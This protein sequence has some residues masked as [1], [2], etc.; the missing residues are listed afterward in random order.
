M[1]GPTEIVTA[2]AG[3]RLVLLPERALW[4]PRRRS[5]LVAD[6]HL[7]KAASFRR[8]GLP[9]PAGTTDDN[10]ARID[11]CL[12]RSGAERLICLGDLSHAASGL[13]PALDERLRT[14]QA[15]H[16]ELTIELVHGNHDRHAGIPAGL[17]VRPLGESHAEPPFLLCHEP[18]SDTGPNTPVL[19]G[20]LHPGIVLRAA[21]DRLRLPCFAFADRIGLLPAFGAFTGLGELPRDR[22]WRAFPVAAGRVFEV[23]GQTG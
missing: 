1:T 4:W 14:W 12:A 3:E 19:A 11:A 15:M 7:G 21:G 8:N 20:H 23:S 9:V 6:V 5:L 2:F 13:G 10:L 17:E 16:R 18:P 22:E